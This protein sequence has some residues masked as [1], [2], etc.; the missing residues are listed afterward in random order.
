MY[1]VK[2]S[3][4]IVDTTATSV[5]WREGCSVCYDGIEVGSGDGR[6]RW[7]LQTPMDGGMEKECYGLGVSRM[8]F[9][10]LIDPAV[11]YEC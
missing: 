9:M 1:F 11:L 7:F 6:L 8:A 3:R 10:V 5:G 2:V 4:G